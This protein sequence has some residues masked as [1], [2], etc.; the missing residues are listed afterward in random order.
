MQLFDLW[1]G[2][3]SLRTLCIYPQFG[4]EMERALAGDKPF[5]AAI[6]RQ[7]QFVGGI[8]LGTRDGKTARFA[9]PTEWVAI[10]KKVVRNLTKNY[11]G[12]SGIDRIPDME[13]AFELA[14]NYKLSFYIS[15]MCADRSIDTGVGTFLMESLAEYIDNVYIEKATTTWWEEQWDSPRGLLLPSDEARSEDITRQVVRHFAFFKLESLY[16]ARLF[17]QTKQKFLQVKTF[18]PTEFD[19]SKEANSNMMY[20][21]VLPLERGQGSVYEAYQ[22]WPPHQYYLN[23][24]TSVH[25]RFQVPAWVQ[26]RQ[27]ETPPYTFAGPTSLGRDTN[28]LLLWAAYRRDV[29]AATMLLSQP[30][31]NPNVQTWRGHTPLMVVAGGRNDKTPALVKIAQMLLEKGADVSLADANGKTAMMYAVEAQNT[32]LL[33]VLT[34][35]MES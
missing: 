33:D 15:W 12:R 7:G 21:P 28:R 11:S 29:L 32:A 6:N 17:W 30:Y 26:N 2:G 19:F 13:S 10:L 9:E 20:R 34:G 3:T 31:V 14:D 23:T 8:V 24:C 35:A 16:I 25:D 5:C 18:D 4:Q 1:E 27:F 22:A